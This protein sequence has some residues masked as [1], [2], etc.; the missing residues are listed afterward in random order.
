M[1]KDWVVYSIKYPNGKRYIGMTGN[2]NK[3]V[4]EHIHA[5]KNPKTP[6]HR[7]INKYK[8]S[9]SWEILSTYNTEEAC[10]RGEFFY[11]SFFHTTIRSYGYNVT[12]GGQ[13][14]NRK[15]TSAEH[16]QKISLAQKGKLRGKFSASHKEAHLKGIRNSNKVGTFTRTPEQKNVLR[17][18]ALKIPVTLENTKTKEIVSGVSISEVA[19][20]I[21]K[22]KGVVSK[23]YNKSQHTTNDGWVVKT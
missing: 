5:A 13:G 23:L 7:A 18:A 8:D 12:S 1:S 10:L 14:S 9:I 19:R 3:R 11:I 16:R 17:E 22:R 2:Y 21:G 6:N 4:K 20:K 15:Y